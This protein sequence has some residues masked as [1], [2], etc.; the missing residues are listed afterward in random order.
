MDFLLAYYLLREANMNKI[1]KIGLLSLI[2]IVQALTVV[3]GFI[4]YEQMSEMLEKSL[5]A[6]K[7]LFEETHGVIID[8]GLIPNPFAPLFPWFFWV[9]S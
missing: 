5:L 8:Y 9:C 1:I 3:G 6:Y 2:A 4:A 7:K